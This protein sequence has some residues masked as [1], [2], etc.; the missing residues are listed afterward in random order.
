MSIKDVGTPEARRQG[1]TYLFIPKP[2]FFN[3][4]SNF[5]FENQYFLQKI[6]V[7]TR[8]KNTILTFP[9]STINAFV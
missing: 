4:K 7:E 5:F 2:R 6:Q 1:K 3:P 8:T 9:F